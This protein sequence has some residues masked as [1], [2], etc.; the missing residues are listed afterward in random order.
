[1][2]TIATQQR[3]TSFWAVFWPQL[4][5]TIAGGAL[6]VFLAWIIAHYLTWFGIAGGML[7]M[8]AAGLRVAWLI[9]S[10]QSAAEARIE[11]LESEF[12]AS[13]R[14]VKRDSKRLQM[15]LTE[16]HE[17]RLADVFAAV[18]TQGFTAEIEQDD[19]PGVGEGPMFHFA[20]PDRSH[21]AY[22]DILSSRAEIIEALR[23][24]GA[25]LSE[26]S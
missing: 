19:V 18:R 12:A 7:V 22:L 6:L 26:S 15:V 2:A 8:L 23:E 17:Q 5:A 10:R 20:N 25:D 11:A 21:W 3:A 24:M 1:V 4:A 13:K 16:W 14:D 9:S